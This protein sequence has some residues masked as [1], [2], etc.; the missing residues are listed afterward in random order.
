MTAP[1]QELPPWMSYSTTVI[2]TGPGGGVVTSTTLLQLPL[3]YYGPSV[4]VITAI[5]SYRLGKGLRPQFPRVGWIF[6]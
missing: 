1:T 6:A 4:S 3:T 5:L 2:M